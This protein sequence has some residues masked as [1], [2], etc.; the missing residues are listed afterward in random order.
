MPEKDFIPDDLKNEIYRDSIKPFVSETAKLV[1]IIPRFLNALLSKPNQWILNREYAVKETSILLE[2]K[3]QS[4]SS[5]KL[6]Q[7]DA[8]VAIPTIMALSYSI[9][10]E[11]LREL[12]ANLLAKSMVIDT[13]DYVHPAFIECIKQMSPL[14]AQLCKE[15]FLSK[16]PAL[17]DLAS[18]DK[19]DDMIGT[20]T[21]YEILETNISG[22]NFA[23]HTLQSSSFYLLEKLGFIKI[24]EHSLDTEYFYKQICSSKEY[25]LLTEKHSHKQN[26]YARKKSFL[27][28][29]FG[30]LF[31]SICIED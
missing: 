17:I 7:P 11:Q 24:E 18:G 20:Y 23:E 4:I 30:K 5:E 6:V 8:Y 1:S 25:K 3:L 16:V 31:V 22:Y 13:K 9:N 2:Q 12:Y 14:D 28:T 27:I 26:L 29:D 15:I 19:F 21:R 10:N